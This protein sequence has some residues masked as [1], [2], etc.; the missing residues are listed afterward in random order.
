MRAR[1]HGINGLACMP[2]IRRTDK[3]EIQPVIGQHLP[4]IPI[5]RRDLPGSLSLTD[6]LSGFF[7][8]IP[9]YIAHGDDIDVADLDESK[10]IALPVPTCSD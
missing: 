5:Q 10:K 2:V 9:I 4:V 1:R 6:Q 7:Q 3:H 8:M